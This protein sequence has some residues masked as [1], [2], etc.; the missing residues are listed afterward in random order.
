MAFCK[1]VSV[2][3]RGCISTESVVC[4]SIL[5][6]LPT[7]REEHV[8]VPFL[9]LVTCCSCTVLLVASGAERQDKESLFNSVLERGE[10]RGSQTRI[11]NVKACRAKIRQHK[12][13]NRL[14]LAKGVK[15]IMIFLPHHKGKNKYWKDWR[16]W[17]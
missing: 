5:H 13:R 3:P 4:Y 14:M 16:G 8:C 9:S 6:H 12:R 10:R 11:F 1:S 15:I 17:Y 2:S 7:R